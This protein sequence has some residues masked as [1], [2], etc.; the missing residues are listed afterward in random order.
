MNREYQLTTALTEI[1][2]RIVTAKNPSTYEMFKKAYWFLIW[3]I[4]E[5]R[6]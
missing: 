6:V 5:K 3:L 2:S 1:E 4:K